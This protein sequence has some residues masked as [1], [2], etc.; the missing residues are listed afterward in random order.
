[1][2]NQVSMV[3]EGTLIVRD[4][5]PMP[6]SVLLS[7]EPWSKDWSRVLNFTPRNLGSEINDA[8][9]T[10]F[11]MASPIETSVLGFDPLRSL[12]TAI[13]RALVQMTTAG[14]NCLEIET[15]TR[16]TFLGFPRLTMTARRRHIQASSR[17]T[18]SS[19]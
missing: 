4:G 16:D 9:W 7:S 15:L 14:L 3:A 12:N 13:S 10:F 2:T 6:P 1:M 5:T 17:L 8:G 11:F 19:A 18:K